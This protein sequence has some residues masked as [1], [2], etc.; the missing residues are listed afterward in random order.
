MSNYLLLHALD[1]WK[2]IECIEGGN[3]PNDPCQLSDLATLLTNLINVALA[4]VST[5]AVIFII[6]GG[7]Q[8]ITSAGNPDN[9]GRAKTTIL[10][11]IIGLILAIISFSIINFLTGSF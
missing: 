2:N 5:I 10:Y 1:L 7:F 8:Y 9:I 6:V 11:A 3:N 4:L